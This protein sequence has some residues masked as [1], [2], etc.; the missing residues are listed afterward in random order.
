MKIFDSSIVDYFEGD[1]DCKEFI[2]E[3]PTITIAEAQAILE[4]HNFTSNRTVLLDA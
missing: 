1:S 4:H 2:A 3:N